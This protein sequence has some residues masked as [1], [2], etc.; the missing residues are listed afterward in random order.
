M[1]ARKQNGG[2]NMKTEQQLVL[3]N[4]VPR[5][6]RPPSEDGKPIVMCFLESWKTGERSRTQTSS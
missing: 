1:A 2:K 4:E 6:V 3:E 5:A